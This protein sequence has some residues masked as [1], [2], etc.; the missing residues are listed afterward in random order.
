MAR[1]NILKVTILGD[2]KTAA[3]FKKAT[4]VVAGFGAATTGALALATREAG[5]FERG[6]A[7]INTLLGK[8]G[9]QAVKGMRQELLE[10][11]RQSGEALDSLTKA[12]YDIISAGFSDAE[13]SAKV[14]SASL[15]IAKGGLVEASDAADLLT[16]A[17]NG[18]GISADE[19]DRVANILF[20]T[21]RLGKTTMTELNQ[22]MG[23][24]FATAR[25]AGVSLE[26]V[27]AAVATITANGIA[28]RE[29]GTALTQLLQALAAPSSEAASEMQALGITLDKGLQP[30]LASLAEVSEDGLDALKVLIPNIRALKAA[31]AA[32]S[33]IETFSANL[34][35]VTE[36]TTGLTEAVEIM[37]STVTEQLKILRQEFKVF[38]VEIGDALL[39]VVKAMIGVLRELGRGFNS[40]SDAGKKWVAGSAAVTGAFATVA[41]ALGGLALAAKATIPA[42]VATGVAMGPMLPVIAALSVAGIGLGV[43][44]NGISKEFDRVKASSVEAKR[45]LNDAVPVLTFTKAQLAAGKAAEETE[46]L[47]EESSNLAKIFSLIEDQT[48]SLEFQFNSLV[49]ETPSDLQLLSA[50][51]REVG[52]TMEQVDAV[53]MAMLNEHF[54]DMD[55]TIEKF[56]G[57]LDDTIATLGDMPETVLP[58]APK[59]LNAFKVFAT[60]VFEDFQFLAQDAFD[61]T[62]GAFGDALAAVIIDGQKFSDV[63]GEGFK[64]IKRAIIAATIELLAYKAVM[65]GLKFLNALGGPLGAIAGF[66][67]N[68][69]TSW[70]P[71][72]KAN[73][74][75]FSVPGT[76][77]HDRTPILASG[78]E[79]VLTRNSS[80]LLRRALRMPGQSRQSVLQRARSGGSGGSV[81]VGLE[82][83]LLRTQAAE[84]DDRYRR[85]QKRR[86]GIA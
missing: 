9:A 79:T 29:A 64:G 30:A 80:D 36:N 18:M 67:L 37:N 12:R 17:L 13:E 47:T 27:G 52:G 42:L 54:A 4:A 45:V 70:V 60:E 43:A 50:A 51:M 86:G 56:N 63:M 3:A 35:E 33:D 16:T 71:S 5:G 44:I 39:P 76:P 6:M 61:A 68:T 46:N 1:D 77:G 24:I 22:S 55:I 38:A 74:G 20:S 72:V 10:L 2:D 19:S 11:S 59:E 82:S 57:T 78:G 41:G 62:S 49:G 83:G 32:G 73:A 48:S 26:E 28:T 75:L 14:L 34:K 7:E 84:I 65:R 53:S 66:F 25:I 31:A 58:R 15:D 69:G 8:Q 40:L 85:I 21:V 81:V 23:Q